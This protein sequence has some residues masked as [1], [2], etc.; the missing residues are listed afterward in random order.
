MSDDVARLHNIESTKLRLSVMSLEA[1]V[2][3]E[4]MSQSHQ[5]IVFE[6]PG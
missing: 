4:V 5:P 1:C 3:T 2:L 6:T